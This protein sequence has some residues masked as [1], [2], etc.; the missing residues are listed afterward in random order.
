MSNFYAE[1]DTDKMIRDKYFPDYSYKGILVEVG[2]ATPTFISTSKHF[3]ENG[4][5]TIHVEP[6]PKFV[7]DHLKVNNEI[8]Q[9][10]CGEKDE[11]DVDFTIVSNKHGE[12]TD[13][14][15]SSLEIKDEYKNLNLNHFNSLEKNIIKVKCRK[16]DSIIKEANI[17]RIDV[18]SI[19]TEGWELEVMKGLSL[20]NP[21]LIVLE[22]LLHLD[23]YNKFMENR[24]Y[25][26]DF[27]QGINYFY[28]KI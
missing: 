4:W 16:L 22:N 17:S 25:K 10:A 28:S 14:S 11:D 12:I 6:N 5:R 7:E 3:K 8:Y 9:Y 13:H 27:A 26:F 15:Y 19:D 24:G 20:I 18:L 1:H 2:A 21:T 23:S